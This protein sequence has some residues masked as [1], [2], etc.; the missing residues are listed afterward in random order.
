MEMSTFQTQRD[1][2]RRKRRLVGIAV[3]IGAA[4]LMSM[5]GYVAM[6]VLNL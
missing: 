4:M 2:Y 5:A 1:R 3:F 6:R